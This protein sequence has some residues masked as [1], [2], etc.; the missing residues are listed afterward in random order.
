MNNTGLTPPE[1]LFLAAAVCDT[2]EGPGDDSAPVGHRL[3][4][5][6]T[7]GADVVEG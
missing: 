1:P 6:V 7:A 3:P 5:S 2:F 4:E